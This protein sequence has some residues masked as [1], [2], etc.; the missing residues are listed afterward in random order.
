MAATAADKD[1]LS[2][3]TKKVKENNEQ[4]EVLGRNV[5][6]FKTLAKCTIN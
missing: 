6:P 2:L 5:Y 3:L 4:N 1:F